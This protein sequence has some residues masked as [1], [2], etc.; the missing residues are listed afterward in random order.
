MTSLLYGDAIKAQ[1]GEAHTP[2]PA[3]IARVSPFYRCRGVAIRKPGVDADSGPSFAASPLIQDDG[4][5]R[6]DFGRARLLSRGGP[7]QEQSVAGS[8]QSASSGE[9]FKRTPK[10]FLKPNSLFCLDKKANKW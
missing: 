3:R 7:A 2:T 10:P 9:R 6:R 5:L 1:A 4:L 8:Q